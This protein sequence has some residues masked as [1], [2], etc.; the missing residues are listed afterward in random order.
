MQLTIHRVEE[1]YVMGCSDRWIF[2]LTGET[3]PLSIS[4]GKTILE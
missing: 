3:N 4:V 1:Y 2:S